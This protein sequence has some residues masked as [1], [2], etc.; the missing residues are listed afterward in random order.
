MAP[1]LSQRTKELIAILFSPQD[2]AE[3]SQW[4]EDE[5]GN[6][7]PLC[8]KLDEYGMERVRFAALR[9]SQG[10]LHRL[11]RAID[12]ARIDWR[13]LLVAAEFGYDIQAHETWAKDLLDKK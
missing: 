4:L 10:N 1:G 13:D 7:L 11:L 6:N 2:V 8:D 9:L 12:E 3:A 5:C